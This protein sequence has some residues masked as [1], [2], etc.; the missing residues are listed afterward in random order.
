[1]DGWRLLGCSSSSAQIQMPGAR[2]SKL[3]C[4]GRKKKGL[5]AFS[6]STVQ[7]RTPR[8]TTTGLRC[9]GHWNG[10]VSQKSLGCFSRTAQMR[11]PEIP[12]TALRYIWHPETDILT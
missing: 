9:I 6:S 7:I 12:K 4:I 1:M 3:H 8:T 5:L 11:M 2:K 10:E